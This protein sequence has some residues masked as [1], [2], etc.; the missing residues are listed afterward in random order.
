MTDQEKITELLMT[1]D[2]N[3]VCKRRDSVIGCGMRFVFNRA[4]E[5]IKVQR[6][7]RGE[8]GEIK[9]TIT[10]AEDGKDTAG[11]VQYYYPRHKDGSHVRTKEV[12]NVE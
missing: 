6:I 11:K 3:A 8:D 10:L 4:G 9:K 2:E 12:R 7:V 5:V 1:A